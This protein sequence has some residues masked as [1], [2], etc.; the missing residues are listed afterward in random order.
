MLQALRPENGLDKLLAAFAPYDALLVPTFSVFEEWSILPSHIT[1]EFLKHHV[2]RYSRNGRS[3]R[4]DFATVAGVAGAISEDGRTV[5]VAS[6]SVTIIRRI[7]S[8]TITA[9]L[10]GDAA[11]ENNEAGNA[12]RSSSF[13]RR[14]VPGNN[15]PTTQRETVTIPDVFIVSASFFPLERIATAR[16]RVAAAAA[17]SAAAGAGA[18]SGAIDSPNHDGQVEAETATTATEPLALTG[19]QA[20]PAFQDK[21][22]ND[23]R[24]R[25]ATRKMKETLDAIKDGAKTQKP[26]PREK[27]RIFITMLTEEIADQWDLW[28][29]T[30][31]DPQEPTPRWVLDLRE[32]VERFVTYKAYDYLM[33]DDPQDAEFAAQ[34]EYLLKQHTNG[35]G[36]ISVADIAGAAP[37]EQRRAFEHAVA[38]LDGLS[39]LKSPAEKMK[40]V[41]HAV[42]LLRQCVT[43][44]LL[45]A[46]TL[47]PGQGTP[48]EVSRKKVPEHLASAVRLCV[49]HQRCNN[50]LGHL[51]FVE[52]LRSIA[53]LKDDVR[54]ELGLL[55]DSV[56]FWIKASAQDAA[57][58]FA[59]ITSILSPPTAPPPSVPPP[60]GK[61]ATI[62]ASKDNAPAASEPASRDNSQRGL[63][64]DPVSSAPGSANV[65][66]SKVN[67]GATPLSTSKSAVQ[68][69]AESFN[70]PSSF[71]Q[72]A[73]GRLPLDR[74][75]VVTAQEI[76]Q[77]AAWD[78]QLE[79]QIAKDSAEWNAEVEHREDTTRAV[80]RLED[81]WEATRKKVQDQADQAAR[82]LDHGDETRLSM[83][84]QDL[85]NL[86]DLSDAA[87]HD[88]KQ[89]WTAFA[90]DANRNYDTMNAHL[91][92]ASKR[93][94]EHREELDK[95]SDTLTAAHRATAAK[96]SE[97]HAGLN[98]CIEAFHKS[99]LAAEA[100]ADQT[101]LAAA[102][103]QADALAQLRNREAELERRERAL[104]ERR[105]ALE[106]EAA[107]ARAEVDRRQRRLEAEAAA[108]AEAARAE[109]T[110]LL[111][112]VKL[113]CDAVEV[114]ETDVA[115][116]E[117]EAEAAR[118]AVARDF[119][120]KTDE[121]EHKR[122]AFDAHA[123]SLRSALASEIQA[124]D[125]RAKTAEETSR[126]ARESAD[127][128]IAE[129][130][131][132][133]AA[134]EAIFKERT[135]ALDRRQSEMERRQ[136][137]ATIAEERSK[138]ALEKRTQEVLRR[139]ADDRKAVADIQANL[140]ERQREL[141]AAVEAL[142][143]RRVELE[144]TCADR[145]AAA[146][147]EVH[148][149]RTHCV[150]EFQQALATLK[151]TDQVDGVEDFRHLKYS[152]MEALWSTMRAFR[153]VKSRFNQVVSQ[154]EADERKELEA[155]K[156]S[157]R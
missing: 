113:R 120:A 32:H 144:Q 116:R 157:G 15:S 153:T 80:K 143:R 77:R 85:A 26:M 148:N 42:T 12:R 100:D 112:S 147:L 140:E 106:A 50:L 103:Q 83:W 58:E 68:Q 63:H 149:I 130:K 53:A 88:A 84:Q 133:T 40:A 81:K 30:K 78:K 126:A 41:T 135:A 154:F 31:P 70:S 118:D 49:L 117:A 21:F 134:A 74:V 101:R 94:H 35:S 155:E 137:V 121:L 107:S 48:A 92:T 44:A 43:D 7:S 156:T 114:R 20:F 24:L 34:R 1:E 119:E 82:E 115:A 54:S 56:R 72:G 96:L 38:S 14:M 62:V 71:P 124:V 138:D 47:E 25:P 55:R 69:L 60:N 65:S 146:A 102:Q 75:E 57:Q 36:R 89:A 18:S 52:T 8:D 86:S 139:A 152:E 104:E 128:H 39:K 10:Q 99:R 28:T 64:I 110:A 129:A 59:L 33:Q 95:R 93:V 61:R 141:D 4:Q 127:L 23:Q 123:A 97:L 13:L 76:K 125:A 150:D 9:H 108:R 66:S 2:L 37:P 67:G 19:E 29:A 51:A 91:E 46:A 142:E 132:Q 90:D 87:Y 131:R 151:E 22:L 145:E 111:A 11:N 3:R 6:N 79:E 16:R 5:S 17:G 105:L 27:V 45:K 136:R 122:A 98:E 109:R 73:V